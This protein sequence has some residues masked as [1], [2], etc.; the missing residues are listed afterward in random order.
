MYT[1]LV[2]EIASLQKQ[3]DGLI[4]PE[5]GRWVDWTPVITQ[6]VNVTFTNNYARY[7]AKDNGVIVTASMTITGAGTAANSIF[8]S[9][10]PS[11]VQSLRT[12]IN[13]VIGHGLVFDSGVGIYTIEMVANAAASW[14]MF[15]TGAGSF[16][17]VIPNFGLA[18]NDFITFVATYEF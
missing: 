10:I 7:K 5:V 9:G 8:I 14:A 6:N 2:K 1:E 12:G 13:A 18:V 16:V 3:V 11:T 17:G 4:K 15:V